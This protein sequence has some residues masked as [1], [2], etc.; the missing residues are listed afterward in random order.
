MFT[1]FILNSCLNKQ[2]KGYKNT[3]FVLFLLFNCFKIKKLLNKL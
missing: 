2:K 1:F 3:L